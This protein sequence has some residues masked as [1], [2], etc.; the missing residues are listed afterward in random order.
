[1]TGTMT[2]MLSQTESLNLMTHQPRL[3][4]LLMLFVCFSTRVRSI[5]IQQER[6]QDR[7]KLLLKFIKIMKV[8]ITK[9]S[10]VYL[11]LC[12][13]VTRAG[14]AAMMLI[15]TA[16]YCKIGSFHDYL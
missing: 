1:M 15:E 10:T 3:Y 7:E 13:T 16:V 9:F 11:A 6:A 14:I 12:K 8:H 4:L 2:R 5:I